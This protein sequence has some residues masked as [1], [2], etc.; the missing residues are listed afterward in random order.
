MRVSPLAISLLAVAGCGTADPESCLLRSASSCDVREL[1]CQE[2]AHAVIACIRGTDH[3]LPQID[4]MTADEWAEANP[5]A[6]PRTPAEQRL[7]DQHTR[8]YE[9]LRFLPSNWEEPE[10]TPIAAPYLSYDWATGTIV[11]VADGTQPETELYSLLYMLAL[12]ARD[13][14]SDLAGLMLTKTGTFDS[15]RA[16]T[17]LYA[18]EAIL[19]A[20]MAKA[21]ELD[22]GGLAER[23]DYDYQRTETRKQLA[24]RTVPWSEAMAL[25]QYYYGANYVLVAFQRDGMSAV[26]A[27]YEDSLAST[28]FALAGS[29]LIEAA[30]SAIDVALP[31]PPA[32]FRYLSQDSYG[33]ALLQLHRARETGESSQTAEQSLGGSWVGDRLLVAGSD[34]SDAVAVVWQIAGPGGEVAETIVRATDTATQDAFAALFPG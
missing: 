1:D 34:T 6:A 19:F 5:P 24:D 25:F 7:W 9:L 13:R 29:N 18:G 22:F 14:E 23:L 27:L 3:P 26:D 8:A 30:F 21:R 10:P 11:V 32:G 17:T 16:L 4:V 31:P 20:D 12:A 28:A 2:H 15:K 33:P